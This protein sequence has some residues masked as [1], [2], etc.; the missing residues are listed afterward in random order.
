MNINQSLNVDLVAS[1]VVNQGNASSGGPI[2]SLPK[3]LIIEILSY[4]A[5]SEEGAIAPVCQSW[6][7]S[8]PLLKDYTV[9][10]LPKEVWQEYFGIEIKEEEVPPRPLN[11]YQTIR[12]DSRRL[13][14]PS[15][16]EIIIPEGLTPNELI[17]LM[18]TPKKG[19][20]AKLDFDCDKV[21]AEHGD[22]RIEKT[23]RLVMTDDVVKGS[24]EESYAYQKELVQG[25]ANSGC[26]L[27]TLIEALAGSV[28]HYVI[29]GERLPGRERATFTRCQEQVDGCHVVLGGSSGGLYVDDHDF[30][31]GDRS[32]AVACRKFC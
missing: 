20:S 18:E 28:M 19:H 3:E 25:K 7:N 10:V 2:N 31:V 14:A 1:P 4:I 11:F 23:Y 8:I 13:S 5:I 9:R 21:L 30:D 16:T 22:K 26:E 12:S 6:N 32:G 24:R 15:S 17:K 27:P 29:S